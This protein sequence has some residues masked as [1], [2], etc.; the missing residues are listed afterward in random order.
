MQQCS[1]A[2]LCR[3]DEESQYRGLDP[4]LLIAS[5]RRLERARWHP[6]NDNLFATVAASDRSIFLYDAQYTQVYQD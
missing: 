2:V 3:L 6:T 1:A 4:V 5:E